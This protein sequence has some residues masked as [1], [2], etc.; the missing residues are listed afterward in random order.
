ELFAYTQ[1]DDEGLFSFGNLPAGVYRIFIEYP[2][3]PID[4]DAFTEF[5]ITE[6]GKNND[7]SITAEVFE[8]GIEIIGVITGIAKDLI[9]ELVVYPNPVTD[10]KV[11]V[12]FAARTNVELKV[13]IADL[14]GKIIWTGTINNAALSGGEGQIDISEVPAGMYLIRMTVPEL[15]NETVLNDKILIE[16]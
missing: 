9:D 6:D 15:Q 8:D 12:R 4:E 1:T 5:E 16:R 11:N 13:E 7:V 3:I 10:G 2:G 14:S